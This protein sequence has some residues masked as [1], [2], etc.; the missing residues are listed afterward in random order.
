MVCKKY[1]DF[2]FE[3]ILSQDNDKKRCLSKVFFTLGNL[4]LAVSRKNNIA[5]QDIYLGSNDWDNN[6]DDYH[7]IKGQID[8]MVE[9]LID[10][11]NDG[12]KFKDPGSKFEVTCEYNEDPDEY[13]EYKRDTLC[14]IIIAFSSGVTVEI[15]I[16]GFGKYVNYDSEIRGINIIKA[17]NMSALADECMNISSELAE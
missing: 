15:S 16:G 8:D 7:C 2:I 17:N 3:S 4:F 12:D 5:T 10:N 13:E 6:K 14:Y 1:S 11:F 9:T